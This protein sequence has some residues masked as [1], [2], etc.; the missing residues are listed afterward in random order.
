MGFSCAKKINEIAIFSLPPEMIGF[1]K[2]HMR[3]IIE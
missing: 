3:T 2:N 1:Y